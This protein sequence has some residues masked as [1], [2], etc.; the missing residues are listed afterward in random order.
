MIQSYFFMRSK[1][2]QI[3]S[4]FYL[5]GLSDTSVCGYFSIIIKNHHSRFTGVTLEQYR[6]NVEEAEKQVESSN[7][8]EEPIEV[9]YFF[10]AKKILTCNIVCLRLRLHDLKLDSSKRYFNIS[11]K[12]IYFFSGRI[13]SIFWIQRYEWKQAKKYKYEW[14]PCAKFDT[15]Q[16]HH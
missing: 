14:Q 15:F 7:P 5:G 13:K 6:Q 4:L 12:T 11:I 3:L 16:W 1:G 8:F 10:L 9:R 2:L